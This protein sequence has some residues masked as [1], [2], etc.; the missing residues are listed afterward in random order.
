MIQNHTKACSVATE[1]SAIDCES[2][3][4]ALDPSADGIEPE[5]NEAAPRGCARY[6]G[7]WY[8]NSH[9][10]GALDGES[11]PV[12]KAVVYGNDPVILA[13]TLTLTP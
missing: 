10:T 1:L 6:Q 7:T 12:C 9:A 4:A 8:F 11:E 5:K 13:L 3:K 2:A